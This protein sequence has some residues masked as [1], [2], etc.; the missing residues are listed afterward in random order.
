MM[1]ISCSKKLCTVCHWSPITHGSQLFH[2]DSNELRIGCIE[3]TPRCFKNSSGRL[4][5]GEMPWIFLLKLGIVRFIAWRPSC[6]RPSKQLKGYNE[7]SDL[8]AS[9]LQWFV[10][11]CSAQ[12][13]Y[14]SKDIE[15]RGWTSYWRK[16][17][18]EKWSAHLCYHTPVAQ[19]TS[20][21]TKHKEWD[22]IDEIEMR[23]VDDKQCWQ[24]HH[25]EARRWVSFKS[26][27]PRLLQG[28]KRAT[29]VDSWLQ[30]TK[31]AEGVNIDP[32]IFWE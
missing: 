13:F 16:I 18:L 28:K 23:H 19:A 5:D 6:R 7:T 1:Y 31:N 20:P 27:H 15:G 3:S 8:A 29:I 4:G 30:N 21:N 25:S 32:F 26:G 22:E 2:D 14:L 12:C 11:S 17:F 9:F 10:A 24:I